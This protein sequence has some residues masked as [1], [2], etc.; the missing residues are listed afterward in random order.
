MSTKFKARSGERRHAR[1]VVEKDFQYRFTLLICLVGGGLFAFFSGL[2]LYFLKLNY[3]TFIQEAVIQFPDVVSNLRREYRML[4]LYVIASFVAMVTAL[5]FLGLVLTHRIAG[6]LYA[7]K[8][9]LLNFATGQCGV[10]LELR[11][12]DEFRNLEDVFNNAMK[13]HDHRTKQEITQLEQVT[14]VLKKS[15]DTEA[16]KTLD[17]YLQQ[18]KKALDPTSGPRA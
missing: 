4:S 10:R 5:F 16:A 6:P 2:L 12:A 11:N 13:E 9:Q 15:K 1:L 3:E 7:L 14:D 8:R 17:D 18:K